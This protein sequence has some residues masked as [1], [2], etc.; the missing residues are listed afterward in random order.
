[1]IRAVVYF[2]LGLI[3]TP[4]LTYLLGWALFGARDTWGV[5]QGDSFLVFFV[6]LWAAPF[7][8][9]Y[10]ALIPWA[11]GRLSRFFR[12]GRAILV[13]LAVYVL[14]LIIALLAVDHSIG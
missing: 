4:L 13:A 7:G 12:E 11:H 8:A 10:W 9:L 2:F 14:G 5:G 6:A 3:V 1:M